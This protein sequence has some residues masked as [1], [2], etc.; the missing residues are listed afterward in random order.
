MDDFIKQ[1]QQR[2]N[3]V[4]L[5]WKHLSDKILSVTKQK[6]YTEGSIPYNGYLRHHVNCPT[7]CGSYIVKYWYRA[8][9]NENDTEWT[10]IKPVKK[11][12]QDEHIHETANWKIEQ[13]KETK[14]INCGSL[15]FPISV[16][17]IN[18][19]PPPTNCSDTATYQHLPFKIVIGI[20]SK[21]CLE[22]HPQ[23][24]R[25]KDCLLTVDFTG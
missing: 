14:E 10:Q 1:Q 11:D 24:I 6:D 7:L 21:R 22:S 9:Q 16:A 5:P 17:N 13:V 2:T 12:K 23:D 19:P 4:I 15:S 3:L 25:K 18:P 8:Q 20:S